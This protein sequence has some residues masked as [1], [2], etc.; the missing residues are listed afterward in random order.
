MSPPLYPHIQPIPMRT[1]ISNH[2]VNIYYIV[3]WSFRQRA[4]DRGITIWVALPRCFMAGLH[5]NLLYVTD[6]HCMAD[7]SVWT[8]KVQMDQMIT[9]HKS[10]LTVLFSF[11]EAIIRQRTFSEGL[12]WSEMK[13]WKDEQPSGIIHPTVSYIKPRR[14]PLS[15]GFPSFISAHSSSMHLHR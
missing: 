7:S 8:L 14:C 2:L 3:A 12:C 11:H 9:H 10:L 6:S 13:L 1:I 15:V 4:N 5:V